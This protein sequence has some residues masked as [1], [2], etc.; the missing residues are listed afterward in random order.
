[1]DDSRSKNGTFILAGFIA[2]TEHWET[3]EQEWKELLR[4][5]P[6]N[7]STGRRY[8]KMSE[9]VGNKNGRRTS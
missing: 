2:T 8:F 5:C 1:M 9:M 4:L 6:R 7:K 3:F